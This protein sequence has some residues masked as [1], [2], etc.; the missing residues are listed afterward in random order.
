MTLNSREDEVP[1]DL[2]QEEVQLEEPEAV[3]EADSNSGV[4]ELSELLR[5][6]DAEIVELKEQ[7]RRVA[8]DFENFRRRQEEEQKRR[9]QHLK[10]DLFRQ[11]LTILDSFER[12]LAAAQASPSI[13]SLTQGMEMVTRE[14]HKLLQNHGVEPIQTEGV[15]FDPNLHEAMMLEE[16]DDVP[17]QAI[18]AELQRGYRMADRVL[19][20]SLV[21]VASNN[22]PQATTEA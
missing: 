9:L 10:E 18:V 11:L 3:E 14:Y 1:A 17:D 7:V 13:E 16:R 6:R 5:T 8:A 19:R 15:L 2:S 22:Q 20:P 21:K 4:A 12:G